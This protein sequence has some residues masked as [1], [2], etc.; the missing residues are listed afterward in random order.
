MFNSYAPPVHTSVVN[1]KL[2]INWLALYARLA[3]C[4]YAVDLGQGGYM[5]RY[6]PR[7]SLGG[8]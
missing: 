2:C 3:N 5:R 8:D 6:D 7:T 4:H 1:T